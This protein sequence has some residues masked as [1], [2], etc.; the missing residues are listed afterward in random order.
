MH[1]RSS[2]PGTSGHSCELHDLQ[3]ETSPA[4]RREAPADESELEALIESFRE[5]L[6]E[7]PAGVGRAWEDQDMAPAAAATAPDTDE[8]DACPAS[9]RPPLISSLPMDDAEFRA[10]VVRFVHRLHEQLRAM[11]EAWLGND[12]DGLA[13]LAHWLK[14]AGGTV[15]FADF[16]EPARTLEQFAKNQQASDIERALTELKELAGSIVV[17]HDAGTPD[18]APEPDREFRI[19]VPATEL[20]SPDAKTEEGS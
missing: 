1:A 4:R 19:P 2:L 16:T 18:P 12:L 13:K 5:T 3:R 8:R 9:A 6:Q 7:D 17:P 11:D 14:G 10:I 15:G 20:T